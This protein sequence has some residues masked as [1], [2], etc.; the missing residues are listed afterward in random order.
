MPQIF[1]LAHGRWG[2]HGVRHPNV[3]SINISIWNLLIMRNNFIYFY[4]CR[5]QLIKYYSFL[6]DWRRR[7]SYLK[8]KPVER[9]CTGESFSAELDLEFIS[10]T[11]VSVL[12]HKI[13]ILPFLIILSRV[14]EAVRWW[15][16]WK[17]QTKIRYG[18]TRRVQSPVLWWFPAIICRF[19]PT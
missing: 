2:T 9:Y 13:F 8:E 11:A 16:Q 12:M 6:K 10:A 7:E 18:P 19:N 17:S 5:K 1:P 14:E 4:H 15:P 3:K